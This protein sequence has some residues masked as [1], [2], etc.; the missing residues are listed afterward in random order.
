MQITSLLAS[1]LRHTT[2]RL[3]GLILFVVCPDRTAFGQSAEPRQVV[4]F[5]EATL[6]RKSLNSYG[7]LEGPIQ[8]MRRIARST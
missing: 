6:G 1:H 3:I 5:T 7:S 2:P 8:E 4:A